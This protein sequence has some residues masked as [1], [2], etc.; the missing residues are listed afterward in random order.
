MAHKH[1]AKSIEQVLKMLEAGG[2]LIYAARVAGP[3]ED[4]N[5]TERHTRFGR[6]PFPD[7]ATAC[8]AL[9]LKKDVPEPLQEDRVTNPTIELC[10]TRIKQRIRR[11]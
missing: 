5:L 4:A 3:C 8:S 9:Q 2:G 1:V 11:L 6:P 7:V 10:P